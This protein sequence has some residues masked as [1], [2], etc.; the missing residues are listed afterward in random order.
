MRINNFTK[1]YL[2][3][4]MKLNQ[5]FDADIQ[6]ARLYRSVAVLFEL[7]TIYAVVWGASVVIQEIISWI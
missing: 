3:V 5:K 4:K 1:N 2:G 6:K 7:A